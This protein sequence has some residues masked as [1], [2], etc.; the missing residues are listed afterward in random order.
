MVELEEVLVDDL[1]PSE[2]IKAYFEMLRF[3]PDFHLGLGHIR[4]TGGMQEQ[5]IENVTRL[6]EEG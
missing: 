6:E 4:L 5:I 1:M 3:D 2:Y